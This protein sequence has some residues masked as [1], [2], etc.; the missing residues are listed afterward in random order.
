[1][2]LYCCGDT[3]DPPKI[4]CPLVIGR[5]FF[6]ICPCDVALD[7]HAS[8]YNNN[9]KKIV[10][11]KNDYIINIKTIIIFNESK[12]ATR[13]TEHVLTVVDKHCRHMTSHV[14]ANRDVHTTACAK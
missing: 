6:L 7:V 13:L 2:T 9:V 12:L 10:F 3:S 8:W 1:M 5:N 14:T 11:L 4:D